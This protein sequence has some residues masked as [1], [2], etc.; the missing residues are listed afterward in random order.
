MNTAN[1]ERMI[2]AANAQ[3]AA[4]A[5]ESMVRADPQ[6]MLAYVIVGLVMVVGAFSWRALRAAR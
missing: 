6:R 2:E 1:L 4:R 3:D 5:V